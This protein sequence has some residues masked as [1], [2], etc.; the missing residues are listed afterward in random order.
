VKCYDAES[1]IDYL[2]TPRLQPSENEIQFR[3]RLW[4]TDWNPRIWVGIPEIRHLERHLTAYNGGRGWVPADICQ[5]IAELRRPEENVDDHCAIPTLSAVQVQRI[6]E[7]PFGENFPDRTVASVMKGFVMYLEP[8]SSADPDS[9]GASENGVKTSGGG[10]DSGNT[11]TRGDEGHPGSVRTE[12]LEPFVGPAEWGPPDRRYA[13]LKPYGI[14]QEGHA[15][16]RA[17][18]LGTEYGTDFHHAVLRWYVRKGTEAKKYGS[19]TLG[20]SFD[21]KVVI[22]LW[23]SH[24]FD[25]EA[26]ARKAFG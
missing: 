24:L 4:I 14:W 6:Y 11:Q 8:F 21:G 2:W 20:P 22:D 15:A 7:L 1:T 19:L 23:G 13:A 17:R 26:D 18:F 10:S 3:I 5:Y 25:N 12:P 9:G 16:S